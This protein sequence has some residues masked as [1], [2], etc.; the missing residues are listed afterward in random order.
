MDLPYRAEYAKSSRSSCKGCKSTIGQGSLRLAVMVQSFHF[1][2]K[3]PNWY[4]FK[5]FFNKQRVKTVDDI[6]HFE[7]LRIDD[8]DKIKENVGVG[9]VIIVPD[10]KKGKKRK[11]DKT[12]AA[13]KKLALKD[14]TIQYAKSG[15]AMCRG[16]EQK[17]LK[18][19]IRISKKDF[20]TD[21]GKQ[22]GGQDMWHHVTCFAQL[23]SSLGY[24][25]CGDKLPGFKDLS[26]ED[27]ANVKNEIP[28]IKQED[29]PEVKK[30]KVEDDPQDKE[31]REQNKII[32]GYR[33]KLKDLSK[34]Q[35]VA[36]LEFNDQDVPQ[37]VDRMLDRLS[38]VMAFGALLPCPKCKDGQLVFNKAGYI[39]TGVLSEWAKCQ[40]IIKEPKR[41]KFVVP[42]DLAQEYKFLKKYRYVKRTRI[43]RD[44]NPTVSVKK[45]AKD[46]ADGPKVVRVLPALYDMEFVILGHPSRGKDVL[47]KQIQSL[48][49]KVTTKI[50]K[51]VMAV[52]ATPEMVEKMGTRISEAETEQVQVVPEDFVDQAKDSAG[53]IPELIIKKS[54]CTW[55][56]D[57]TTRLPS[58]ASSSNQKSEKSRS[59]FI[60]SVPSKVKLKLKG[61]G[62]VDP[63]SG[64]EDVAHVYQNGEDKFTAVL[65]LTDV[66][67]NKNSYYKL[68]VLQS[69]Q[70]NRFWLFRSWGR[71]G[72]TIGGNKTEEMSTLN[73][74]K[75]RF[76][77]LYLEKS[78]NNWDDRHDFVKMPALMYPIDVDY[79]SDAPENYNIVHTESKLPKAVQDLIKLIFDVNQMKKLMLEF[80]LDTEKMPLGKLSQ[81]Q[82]NSAFG[83]LSDL[84]KMVEK[85]ASDQ[86][87]I[88]ATN[89]F[90]TFIP[91]SFGADEVPIL[92]DAE[93]IKQKLE[94]L[95]S[96][97]ELEIAYNL[98]KSSGSEHT[99]DSYYQQLKAE[100][101]VLHKEHEHFQIIEEYIKNTHAATHGSYELEVEDIFTIA[102]EGE[103]KR[104]KPFRKLPNRKLLWHGS[105]T[106]NFAGII[107]QGLRIAPPE[108]PVTGYM[109]GKGIY[110]ADMVSKS[111]N[112]CCTNPS[113]PTGLL[114]VCEVALGNVHER[115]H[116]DYVV[117]LPKGKHSV[118]GV[119]R[120]HPDPS[121]VKEIEKVEVPLG[122][123]VPNPGT[124]ENS[125]LYNEYIV[126]D[127]AQVRIRYLARVNFKYKY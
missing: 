27:Q 4:H 44:V 113:S 40:N 108:A 24:Y 68:Q 79:S 26:K 57:P 15:R 114:L 55:G 52:I 115:Q 60:S 106:Q 59:R 127:I 91:H 101:N 31:Y 88:E 1:D 125:L 6:E 107:S 99:V 124:E 75:R 72:T 100:I 119:G 37:G 126:Y 50:S 7:S 13:A 56:S 9:D 36:L 89:R 87:F 39:C 25:E 14:F 11:G 118:K 95:D 121:Y 17:I 104:Y 38:D 65:G 102:R 96:L 81:R 28:A 120:T 93:V 46:E 90:Y 73:E 2:G 62:A 67:S 70:G 19:E 34:P 63:D 12:D 123:P 32:F 98:M 105:R 49:G 51:T 86:S 94:M 18:D 76:C 20:D 35:M 8:Q 85:G 78:G 42:D 64:L 58:V 82:I 92:K 30:V 33:D 48:G 5:C 71:I 3:Q 61:G 16:C 21:I 122:K 74:A 77:D 29:F 54:I 22:Y 84:Q 53:K 111:A 66:Q 10:A 110:F 43:V 83:V 80:E 103:E 109:F 41:K 45:V 47:K 97:R 117:Q 116:A 112:Y 69:D 23:R